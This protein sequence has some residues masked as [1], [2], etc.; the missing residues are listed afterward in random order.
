[1]R[2]LIILRGPMGVGKSTWIKEKGL[3]DYTL[4][5]D[6]FRTL[7]GS[8]SLTVKGKRA[9]NPMNESKVWNVLYEVLELRMSKGEFTVIDATHVKSSSFTKYKKLCEQYMYRCYVVEFYEDLDVVL[10]RNAQRDEVKFVPESVVKNAHT[11]MQVE[12]PPRWVTK[13]TPQAF[14]KDVMWRKTNYSQYQN[15]F[16]IGDIHGSLDALKETIIQ[17]NG[18]GEFMLR[19]DSMY[20]FVGDYLDR[21]LQNAETLNYLMTIFNY[22]NVTMLTGNHEIHLENWAHDRPIHS[23]R[24]I[25]E[26]QVEIEEAGITKQ[27]V[28]KMTRKLQQ[29]AWFDYHG[30][31]Y[32]VTHGGLS[33]FDFSKMSFVST[34]QLIRG[35]GDY[36]T[37]IDEEW[38][39]VAKTK[40]INPVYQV[41]GHR[42]TYKVG[43]TDYKYSINLEGDVEYNGYLRSLCLNKD[44]HEALN[45]KNN[46]GRTRPVRSLDKPVELLSVEEFY[47]SASNSDIIKKIQ[48]PNDISSLNFTRAA[49]RKRQWNDLTVHARGLFINTKHMDIVARGYEKFFNYEENPAHTKQALSATM[50]FPVTLYHKYNGYLGIISYD[51][52]AKKMS[53]YTKSLSSDLGDKMNHSKMLEKRF[54]EL[55][56]HSQDVIQAVSEASNVS[57]MV[58]V[59]EPEFD[60]HIIKYEEPK[61]VVLDLIKNQLVF[62]A[63]GYETLVA[64]GRIA[65]MKIKKEEHVFENLAEYY[66]FHYEQM[67]EHNL[68]NEIEGYLVEDSAGFRFKLKLPYYSMWKKLRGL[69]HSV[70]KGQDGKIKY[71]NNQI[72]QYF[73]YFLKNI[74]EDKSLITDNNLIL[75][76]DM[77]YDW[78]DSDNFDGKLN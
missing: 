75:L 30:R 35:V 32:I 38:N 63:L 76:R 12:Q 6:D 56:E 68:D 18:Y 47:Q 17:M 15:V 37:N 7:V 42:N 61:L 62:E 44:G 11:K 72:E 19:D 52:Y 77:F 64:F 24:F 58:E 8:P 4:S 28:R 73:I 65:N 48:L 9:I 51:K 46:T 14:S 29:V 5:A 1:M 36:D 22:K 33:Y 53:F 40:M 39:D 13:T 60:P 2:Q 69:M 10:E 55:S 16:V 20:I 25:S 49:F 54:Y 45:V 67:D 57:I 50:Q 71:L 59:I 66:K 34:D 70:R 74:V 41:H 43:A 26:T 23:R 27:D 21:G 31:E 78:I 3:Q